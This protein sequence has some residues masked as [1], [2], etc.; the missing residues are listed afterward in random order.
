[1]ANAYL[2][3]FLLYI[4][5]FAIRRCAMPGLEKSWVW[6][7]GIRLPSCGVRTGSRFGCMGST[8]L[9]KANG[10]ARMPRALLQPECSGR[11]LSLPPFGR[12]SAAIIYVKALDNLNKKE[13]NVIIANNALHAL[14]QPNGG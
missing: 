9:R 7:I 11:R 5:F 6:L 2:R 4:L 3:A 14:K 8:S 10:T 1:M 12:A 13:V